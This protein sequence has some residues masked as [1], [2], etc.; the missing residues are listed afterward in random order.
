MI[1]DCETQHTLV[2][3]SLIGPFRSWKLPGGLEAQHGPDNPHQPDP[4][5]RLCLLTLDIETDLLWQPRAHPDAGKPHYPELYAQL[6]P[7][8]T[9]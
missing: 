1:S 2:L 8:S 7:D 4:V 5:R 9:S 3:A 6:F